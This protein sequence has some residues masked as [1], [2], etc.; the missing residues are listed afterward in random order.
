MST[1]SIGLSSKDTNLNLGSLLGSAAWNAIVSK[2]KGDQSDRDK[3]AAEE[4]GIHWE[5]PPGDNRSAKY[6]I[7]NSPL[8]RDL[9]N[10]EDVKDMLKE[11]V[12]DF[13]NDS[14][15]AYRAVLVLEHIET[16]DSDGNLN[17]NKGVGNGRVDGF[18]GS[19]QAKHGTEAGRLKDFGKYGFEFLKGDLDKTAKAWTD[20]QAREQAAALGIVWTRPPGD[21][22]SA[23]DIIEDTPILKNLGNQSGVKDMLKDRVGDFEKDADAAYRAAQILK[24]I[25][26]FD[27]D[28]N[29]NHGK[30]VGDGTVQ[31]FTSSDEAKPNTE[32]GRLQDFGKY[33]F[34]SL[35]GELADQLAVSDD[36]A[37]REKAESLGIDWARP[38]N[39]DRSAQEIIDDSPLLRNLGNQS[40]VREMLKDQ[41]GD[42]ERDADA[43]YRAA[44][45]LE[46]IEWF[47]SNGNENHGSDI[48]N[49]AINGFT[50][51]DEAKPDT[52][53]GR[54]QDFGKYGFDALEGELPDRA[55]VGDD[56]EAR[57]A[58]EDLG[59]TWTLPDD[60]ERSAQEIID[61]TPILEGLENQSGVRDML[62]NQVGD[63]EHDADAAYR[64]MQVLEHIER[65]DSDGEI[66]GGDEVANDKID[67]FSGNEVEDGTEADRLQN[68]GQDGFESLEGTLPDRLAVADDDAAREQAEALG[69]E[70]SRPEGDDRSAKDIIDNTPLLE[71]LGNQSGI[72]TMLKDRV[73]DYEND[74]D[75]AYR[76]KQVLEHIE[77]FDSDGNIIATK[78]VANDKID[79]FTSSDEAKHGT[80]AGRLQDFGKYG[81][82]S[83][84]GELADRAAAGDD[85]AAREQA[86]A[87]G[88]EW[89]RPE[90]DDRTAKEII[91]ASPLLRD[92]GNQSGIKDML[93]DRIGDYEHDADAAYR[94]VQVLEHVERFDSDGNAPGDRDGGNGKID[95]FTGGGDIQHGTEAGRLKDFGK[96][97]FGSLEG[98]M[99]GQLDLSPE[100]IPPVENE[101]EARER[102]EALGIE[103]TRPEGDVRS[104]KEIIEDSQLLRDLGN[105]SGVKDMLKER[106]GDFEKDPD[107]AYR[108]VQVLEHIESFDSDGNRVVA[109]SVDDG[110]INGFTGSG[111]AKHGTEAGRLQDF[112]KYGFESL[113]GKEPDWSKVGKDNAAREQAEALGVEWT[114]PED[115]ERSV[116]DIIADTPLLRDLGNQSSIKDML[117]ARVGDFENDADAAYRAKQVLERIET[118]GNEGQYL[119]GDDV[120][121]GRI[122]GFTDSGEAEHGTEA[123]RLQDFGKYGFS[124]LEG[125]SGKYQDYLEQNPNAD[126]VSK[127]LVFYATIIYENY[128]AIKDAAGGGDFVTLEDIKAFKEQASS[129]MS[130]EL[131]RALDFWSQPGSFE[132]LETSLDKARYGADGL[133]T[134]EDV[135]NWIDKDAPKDAGS[136]I[137]Y[138]LETA[139][140]NTVTDVDTQMFDEKVFEHPE[141]YSAKEKAAVLRDLEK[142]YN[143]VLMGK[144][145][146]MWD[147][148]HIKEKLADRAGVGGDPDKLLAE[149][150][151]HISLLSSDPE[152]VKFKEEMGAAALEDLFE[153]DETLKSALTDTYNDEILTGKA[154][155]KL[156]D[157]QDGD[158]ESSPTEALGEFFQAGMDYQAAL[159]IDD[160]GALQDAVESSSHNEYLQEHYKESM[161]T[162]DRLKELL[163]DHSLE[164]AISAFS[165]EVSVYNAAL[166]PEF[167]ESLDQKLNDNFTEILQDNAFKDASFD[168]MKEVFGVD[169]GD[170]LDEEKIRKLIDDIRENN[171]D[172]IVNSDG[173]TPTTDQIIAAFR[174]Q[175]DVYRQGIKTLNKLDLLSSDSSA[176]DTL[177]SGVLH[178]VSGLFIAGVTIAK[179]AGNA[180]DLTDRQIVDITAGSILTAD[181]ITEGGVKG[182]TQYLNDTKIPMSQGDDKVK[183]MLAK[184]GRN[185]GKIGDGATIFGGLSTLAMGAYAIFDGV[186]MLR[187]GDS[188]SGGL[189]ITSGT[190]STMLGVALTAEGGLGVAGVV[191]PRIIS[192]VAGSAGV[193]AAVVALVPSI[194]LVVLNQSEQ[195]SRENDYADLLGEY[196]EK[197]GIDGRQEA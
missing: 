117:K 166:D 189:S 55:A 73:G 94:A 156:W 185:I 12:G 27:S 59:I 158:D 77:Q 76:A 10:Q 195:S 183:D 182:Y 184:H 4:L 130:D 98:D 114:L 165:L 169:G 19:G 110:R 46:H 30:D 144:G 36:D 151:Q 122:D 14:D 147:E 139:S 190:L 124:S 112:G 7:E 159:G 26:R 116:Q 17:A 57:E 53:A 138:L 102:A 5:R 95:G 120:G 197:Y 79:G 127:K 35:K 34:E 39:D 60:D 68:F 126:E 167:T 172:L 146:G 129:Y 143:L 80:E 108:A 153:N 81:F 135:S 25:E 78:E 54:L 111:D 37:A 74:A 176:R 82:E 51:S 168:D 56:D 154:L 171:P 131:E 69:I 177:N 97:G 32:A 75:A 83:L 157:I 107:A 28:G 196:V 48:G 142:A 87:L 113:E 101:E 119:T 66:V 50:N 152:V 6:I 180:G 64:A 109:G 91:D 99:T 136:S 61:D 105:Q 188:V 44:Q 178:A 38:D 175:W 86:E 192:V 145:A 106:V 89:T 11:R 42:F 148:G 16:F 24:H 18:T 174:G 41:V 118:Y 84:N 3:E 52:E 1:E 58:A 128:D 170:K 179:G 72:K 181:L 141:K 29:E 70:W 194:V 191:V 164:E 43:A 132:I 67:G 123:G 85:E 137:G 15:A 23:S 155:D 104:V 140:A 90:D 150:Q 31:G 63:F 9:G 92:L 161:V 62:K 22:R 133:L 8:L 88:I 40:G 149:I 103:W 115:D 125:I 121:N 160:I 47:D 162:G 134:K 21:D 71:N 93:K 49:G 2:A 100:D 45:V 65:F 187:D 33:G 20:P 186:Q 13:E 193:A 173:T 163:E 96:H